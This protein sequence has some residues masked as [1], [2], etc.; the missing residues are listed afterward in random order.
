[1]DVDDRYYEAISPT[2][3]GKVYPISP[4]STP[5]EERQRQRM[6]FRFLR[7]LT[8][9]KCDLTGKPMISCYPE[10]FGHK[11]YYADDWWSDQWDPMDYGMEFDPNRPFFD[12]FAELY[13]RVPVMNIWIRNVE[14]CDFVNG[15]GESKNC[16]LCFDTL[17]SEDCLYVSNSKKSNSCLDCYGI[18]ECELCYDCIDCERCYELLFSNRCVNTRNSY[19]MTDCRNCENCIGCTNLVGKQYYIFNT[20]ATKE[21]F[22]QYRACLASREGILSMYADVAERSRQFPRRAYF[23]HNNEM[24]SGDAIYNAKSCYECYDSF[25]IENCQ[26]GNYIINSNNCWDCNYISFGEWNYNCLTTHPNCSYNI[27]CMYCWSGT[28]HSLY[29][30]LLS[31]SAYCFGCSGLVKKE[32][33]ILNKQYS[34][35]E[36][37]QVAA[38]IAEQ[39]IHDGVWGEFFP[40]G[41]S[42][43]PLNETVAQDL[44]PIEREEAIALGY[45]WCDSE[46]EATGMKLSSNLVIQ[47]VSDQILKEVLSCSQCGKDYK[48]VK[49]ELEF[50]RQMHLPPPVSCW[51]CRHRT[52]LGRRNRPKLY[53]RKCD[54]CEVAMQSSFSPELP[55]TVYCERCYQET[56]Y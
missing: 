47:S 16:Y 11:V 36:Y 8:K 40:A 6:S 56:I 46:G 32:Y 31:G 44:D 1:M 21:E 35:D 55:D 41:M 10:E 15:V 30:H 39:M 5:P 51:K 14:N 19:F 13:K 7:G 27:G 9:R 34:K 45:K 25:E 4:S 22:E 37:E 28:H 24:F 12:Q 53:E 33:C 3:A 50:Y 17:F 18:T 26:Y 42:P 43:A 20:K 29:S 23:G 38:K 49:Q 54:K 52:R 48:I 2:F